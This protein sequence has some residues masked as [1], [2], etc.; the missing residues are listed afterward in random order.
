M[1]KVIWKFELSTKDNQRIEM[2]IEAEKE[3]R[4]FEIFETGHPINYKG[5]NKKYIGTYQ[6][7]DGALVFHVFEYLV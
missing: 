6:L 4:Y 2:P 3:K 5:T 1:K 7:Q